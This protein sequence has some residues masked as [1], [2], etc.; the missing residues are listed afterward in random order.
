[1]MKRTSITES[2]N[3]VSTGIDLCSPLEIVRILRQSDSQIFAGWKEYPALFDPEIV[4]KVNDAICKVS[5]LLRRIDDQ[6]CAVVV[7]GSGTSGRLAYFC[8]TT[9]NNLLRKLGKPEVFYYLIAGGDKY[10]KPQFTCTH[11]FRALLKAQE[12]KEDDAALAVEDLKQLEQDK[13]ALVYIGITCGK[14]TALQ[15]TFPEA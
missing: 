14:N 15:L 2:S 7:S 6:K 9:F 13:D 12:L 5:Q 4:N 8:C 3:P 1:M 11:R 10:Q